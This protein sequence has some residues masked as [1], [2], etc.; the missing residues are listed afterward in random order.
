M[1]NAVF[2]L[3]GLFFC[4]W[5]PSSATQTPP[6]CT[7]FI[8]STFAN[9][10]AALTFTL[11]RQGYI[12][13]NTLVARFRLFLA[14]TRT[15]QCGCSFLLMKHSCGELVKLRCAWEREKFNLRKTY[16]YVPF[17]TRMAAGRGF[18][19]NSF[20]PGMKRSCSVWWW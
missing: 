1:F 12:W 17:I 14:H 9:L 20:A 18:L 3:N 8:R 19:Q 10:I 5:Q 6:S 11:L 16:N 7:I 13:R 4:C 2:L 15:P